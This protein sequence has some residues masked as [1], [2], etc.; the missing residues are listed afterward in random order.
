MKLGQRN[1]LKNPQ[2]KWQ[3]THL[4]ASSTPTS[5]TLAVCETN[6]FNGKMAKEGLTVFWWL[7]PLALRREYMSLENLLSPDVSAHFN[8]SSATL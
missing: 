6:P 7:M 3:V 8:H 4:K 5:G 1:G 2:T